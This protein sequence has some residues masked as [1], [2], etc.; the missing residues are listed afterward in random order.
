MQTVLF[1]IYIPCDDE[2]LDLDDSDDNSN[3]LEEG[4]NK[5]ETSE[6][7]KVDHDF[8]AQKDEPLAD[9]SSVTT[10]IDSKPSKVRYKLGNH[11]NSTGSITLI[12]SNIELEEENS[13]LDKSMREDGS[14]IGED[15]VT[16]NLIGSSTDATETHSEECYTIEEVSYYE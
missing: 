8:A 9:N 12:T 15:E 16:L 2:D 4:E 10:S 13:L 6:T 11:Q 3:I 14:S 7:A 5:S 1:V